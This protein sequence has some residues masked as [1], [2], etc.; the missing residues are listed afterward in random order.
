MRG[1]LAVN[2]GNTRVG[3]GHFLWL[4]EDGGVPEPQRAG[5]F[6][7]P[8]ASAFEP[9][10]DFTGVEAAVVASVNPSAEA[11]VCD[12]IER[13][14]GVRPLRFPQDTAEAVSARCDEPMQVGADRLANAVAAWHEFRTACIIVD[15]G[16]AIT[17]DAVDGQGA[18]VG[19]AILPGIR[20]C[21]RSLAEHT[22]LLP[23]LDLAT[24]PAAIGTNTR[25]AIASGVLRGLAGAID[26][27]I[28]AV[29]EELDPSANIII[30]GGDAGQLSELCRVPLEHRPHLTLAGLA[31]T[32]RSLG[33]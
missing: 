30:T 16:T 19:G 23:R 20:L 5:A 27:L 12:W 25:D 9:A 7:L 22:A 2:I 17:V 28:D 31:V 8:Q 29:G 4:P 6:A 18:F 24:T 1:L 21:A 3:L 33:K 10:F 13:R 15:A 26:R 14:V 11:P 32:A